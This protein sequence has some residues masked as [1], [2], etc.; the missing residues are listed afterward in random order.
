MTSRRHI[1]RDISYAHSAATKGGRTVIRLMENSTGRIGLIKRADGYERDVANGRDFWSVMVE[2]Y[3]LSLDVIGGSLSNIPQDG[4]LIL[5]ANHPYGILDGLMMGHILSQTRGDFRILAHR[6]FRKA[7]DINRII[8]PISFDQTKEAMK[9]NLDTRK[10][11][12]NYLGRGGA[13]GIFPGGTVSTAVKPF[14]QPMDPGWR[15]FTARMVGKSN[16]TVVPVYF[17]GHTSRLFQIASHLHNTLRM[18]LLIKEFK[19]RVDTPVKVVVGDPIGRDIL[20]PMAKDSRAMMDFLRKATYELSPKP[21]K[22]Y[23]YGYEFEERHR[24]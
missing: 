22:S 3:G 7:E 12:L 17:D 13:I 5:I 14:G 6:V 11:S 9:L 1:A 15:G 16:A 23:D 24:A 8:L 10:T 21:L 18:G 19:K 20:D 4:P 2:R